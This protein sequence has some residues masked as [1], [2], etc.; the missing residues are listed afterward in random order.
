MRIR[1]GKTSDGQSRPMREIGDL[2]T[3]PVRIGQNPDKSLSGETTRSPFLIGWK[4]S[5]LASIDSRQVGQSM[6]TPFK[7]AK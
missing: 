1:S 2:A 6:N 5:K 3:I 7:C 4:M